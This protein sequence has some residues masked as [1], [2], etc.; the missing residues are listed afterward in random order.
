MWPDACAGRGSVTGTSVLKFAWLASTQSAGAD[1]TTSAEYIVFF[2]M[3][4]TDPRLAMMGS[5][6]PSRVNRISPSTTT[7]NSRVSGRMRGVIFV[8]GAPELYVA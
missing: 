3:F 7:K 6:C 5:G 8:P 1:P 4:T 2:G